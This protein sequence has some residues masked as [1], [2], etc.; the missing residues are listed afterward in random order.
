MAG[1]DVTLSAEGDIRR[2]TLLNNLLVDDSSRQLPN[3]WLYRRGYVDPATGQFGSVRVTGG[4]FPVNDP[5]ASTAWW[6]D[7]TNFFQGVGAL[8]GGDVTLL[9][10]NDIINVD[11]VVPTNARMASH[12]TN[13]LSIA[14]DPSKLVELG[15]G[16][17][18]IRAGNNIDGGVYYVERGDGLLFAGGA[19]TTNEARSP[20]LG[21][22]RDTD[23]IAP[24]I[25]PDVLDPLTWLPTTLF[26]G[27]SFFDVS[28][29]GDILIG[30]VTNPFLMPQGLNNKFWY[31]TYFNT[32][33]EDAGASVASFGGG[34]THRLA[35]SDGPVLQVWLET[36]NR[37][38]PNQSTPSTAGNFQP[39]IRLAEA[40][41]SLFQTLLGVNGP[42]LMSTA[43]AGDIDVVGSMTL[44]PSPTG[45]LELAASGSIIGLNAAGL[46]SAPGLS[47]TFTRWTSA[48]INLSDADPGLIPGITSPLAFLQIIPNPNVSIF[49]QTRLEVLTPINLFF[50]ETGSYTGLAASSKVQQ[51]LHADGLLHAGDD[52]PVRIYAG[53]GDI[54]GLTL[55]TSKA[56][57]IAA[58]RDI[59]DVSFYIQH[60]SDSDISFVSA[61]R[62]IIPYNENAPLRS[63]A[64]DLTAGN[65]VLD[66][67]NPLA[68]DIQINGP[69]VLEVLAG[70]N[71][72]LGSGPNLPDG[73]GIGITSVG[74]A[75]NPF[76][77][78]G[79]ADLVVMAGVPGTGGHGP[80]FGL[81]GSSLDF[82][83]FIDKYLADSGN[84]ESAYLDKLGSNV[85]FE[86][87]T[88]EQQALVALDNFYVLLRDSGRSVNAAPAP[89]SEG[90]AAS[91][92]SSASSS[93][94]V[95]D[96]GASGAPGTTESATSGYD[97]GFAAIDVLFGDLQRDGDILTQ[98][99]NIRTRTGGALSLAA[100]GGGVIMASDIFGNPLTPPGVV[101]EFGGAVSIFTDGNVDI[102]QAR[103]FTLRG[104]DITIW[105]SNGD[106]AAGNAP[107][108]VVSAPP[109][110][111]IID[112]NTATV[113][114]DL[115]GLATGGGIG[116]L[117]AVE[118]I[119]AGNVDLIAPNG[120][121]DA[122]DAGIRVTGNL[123]IAAT[124]VLNASNIQ[125]SGTSSGVSSA[126]PASAPSLGGIAASSAS[127]AGAAAANQVAQSSREKEEERKEEAESIVV[128]EVIGYGGGEGGGASSGA[129]AT[130]TT[131][132]T[133]APDA[134]SNDDEER[135]KKEG[136]ANGSGE[137][138]QGN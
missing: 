97:S 105:S 110:R 68:G 93:G 22:L 128:V 2:V 79:G 73:T 89:A 54:T 130:D 101:T 26:V 65:V 103:I 13:G 27:K 70:R 32:Y 23:V 77:P 76:L 6:I 92:D 106:I 20:S 1:G 60:V 45:D 113:Q 74:N 5:A 8:G 51:A 21:I 19:I 16:D 133:P 125:S 59:S 15:G 4:L 80:A 9:S 50:Q 31:K 129:P 132:G 138:P 83:G 17:L 43:F 102:G 67:L 96:T 123:N 33:S 95:A 48:T 108:T 134:T 18:V 114:T 25:Q 11:A 137:V 62:D 58:F 10:G 75:R 94:A 56:A 7:Y 119:P 47:G 29:R 3:N 112:V 30:P 120:A 81:S 14:P 100:P 37:L 117:A 34:V 35:T 46:G 63:F 36:Q 49:R 87:L 44:F 91:P 126:A 72:D 66:Q 38:I 78:F 90:D 24:G 39:W 136:D 115:G 64:N 122:G 28:A 135:R 55:F 12:D 53:D 124:T 57:Q 42:N 69:G 121:V 52:Q 109:T 116:V 99:R 104:G 84:I 41:P 111:V 86:D 107:K 61:G 98:S 85:K 118:G 131:N 71:A 40:S 88:A 82:A 127:A